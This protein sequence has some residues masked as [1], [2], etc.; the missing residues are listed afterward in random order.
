MRYALEMRSLVKRILTFWS[1]AS[2]C[3]LLQ[4]CP[5]LAQNTVAPESEDNSPAAKYRGLMKEWSNASLEY[6]T[7]RRA[8]AT[9][10]EREALK[11]KA[12]KASAYSPQLLDI[13]AK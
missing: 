6:S 13:A 11:T 12:P 8:A 10:A 2:V 7:A 5:A 3:L 4:N 1:I 9:D